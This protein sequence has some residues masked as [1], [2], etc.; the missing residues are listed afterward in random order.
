MISAISNAPIAAVA[1]LF[2]F[3]S[4][5][6]AIYVNFIKPATRRRLLK[7]CVSAYFIVPTTLRP[8]V[9]ARQDGEEHRLKEISL[10]PN[11]EVVVD[12]IMLTKCSFAFSE[13]HAGFMGELED[14]PH[15]LKYTNRFI[16]SGK[17]HEVDP[18]K[19]DTE[20]YID[21][22]FHYHRVGNRS[23]STE[24]TRSLA[25]TV[26]TNRAGIYPFQIRFTSDEDVGSVAS[27]YVTVEEKFSVKQQCIIAEH[28]RRGR[29]CSRGIGPP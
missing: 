9:Y 2:A 26:R 17:H 15:V 13:I 23:W 19:G 7:D 29:E 11:A 20:D 8:C 14:K 5:S 27:L 22:N 1:A 28:I 3:L 24:T 18:S 16:R 21:V 25:F 6:V 12:L 10:R 4:L